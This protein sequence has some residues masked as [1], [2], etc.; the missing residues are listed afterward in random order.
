MTEGIDIIQQALATNLADSNELRRQAQQLA[1]G[2]RLGRSAFLDHFAV[3]SEFEYKKQAMQDGRIM[4][5]AHIGLNDI[6]ATAAALTRIHAELDSRQFRLDRAGFAL[7]RRMGLPPQRRER[8]VRGAERWA[9]MTADERQQAQG[10]FSD[11]RRLPDE[12]RELIRDR[13]DV[14]KSLSAG[15]QRRIREN[16]RRFNRMNRDRRQK[17]RDRYHNMTPEQ[18]Q[19]ARDRMRGRPKRPTRD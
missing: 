5:H 10:R 17:M 11:W 3:E 6:D 16:F 19:R 2:V 14:Y 12:R 7:D 4:Y 8:L 18:R 13:Y 15:E 1:S 9:M